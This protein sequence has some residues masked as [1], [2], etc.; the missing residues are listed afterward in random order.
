M[1]TKQFD[2]RL[3]FPPLPAHTLSTACAQAPSALPSL[4]LAPIPAAPLQRNMR[5]LVLQAKAATLV[6]ALVCLGRQ[7]NGFLWN[8]ERCLFVKA[9]AA[10][11]NLELRLT[12]NMKQ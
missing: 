4:A 12:I 7:C 11:Q 3:P 10:V 8:S 5:V 2:L 9:G 6:K 1:L